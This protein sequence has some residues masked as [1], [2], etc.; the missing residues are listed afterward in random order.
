MMFSTKTPTPKK[1]KKTNPED[2]LDAKWFPVKTPTKKPQKLLGDAE[3][4]RLAA[5][6]SQSALSPSSFRKM[7]TPLTWLHVCALQYYVSEDSSLF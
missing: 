4:Q 5:R 6:G 2:A 7:T 1:P 3:I